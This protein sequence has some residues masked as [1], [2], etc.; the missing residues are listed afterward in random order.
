MVLFAKQKQ[1]HRCREQMYGQQEGKGS[2]DKLGIEDWHIY[3]ID[4]MY[5]IDN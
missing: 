2:W 5:K 1:R 4:S 3:T